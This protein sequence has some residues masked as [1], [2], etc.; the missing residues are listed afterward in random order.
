MELSASLKMNKTSGCDN[1]SE[2][3]FENEDSNSSSIYQLPPTSLSTTSSA[4]VTAQAAA[5][6]PAQTYTM[7]KR[8][9]SKQTAFKEFSANSPPTA[10]SEAAG[11]QS[12]ANAAADANDTDEEDAAQHR[13]CPITGCD[14]LGNLDGVSERHWSFDT[15]LNYFSVKQSECGERRKLVNK[16]LEAELSS[17]TRS[18]RKSNENSI[19]RKSLR[20]KVS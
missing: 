4:A 1:P 10:A 16:L 3:F 17:E 7:S 6:V 5:S 19:S 20:N 2:V 15:C 8:L 13:Q 14:S 9:K 12:A 11:E 18:P